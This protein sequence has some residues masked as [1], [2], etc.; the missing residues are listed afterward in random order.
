[1]TGGEK[2]DIGIWTYENEDDFHSLVHPVHT[3]ES[4]REKARWR[5][6][7]PPCGP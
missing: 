2:T 4:D 1:M 5:M 7:G 3:M 6:A